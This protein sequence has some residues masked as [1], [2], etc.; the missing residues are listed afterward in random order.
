LPLPKGIAGLIQPEGF[1]MPETLRRRAVPSAPL[2]SL[3]RSLRT[4]TADAHARLDA[5][6]AASDLTDRHAYGRFLTAIASALVPLETALESAGVARSMPDW[7]ERTRS[8]AVLSD[9]AVLGAAPPRPL[10]FTLPPLANEPSLFG[11]LYVLEGSRLGARLLHARVLTSPDPLVRRATAYLCHGAGESLW[12]S[13]VSRLEDAAPG[14]DQES[15]IAAARQ[16]F[17][18]FAQAA[19]ANIDLETS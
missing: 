19:R 14:L 3:R 12:R 10:G 15:V 13:F 17:D 16:T 18:M 11:T 4:A 2:P 7:P 5:R 8:A 6:L 1:F 9:L